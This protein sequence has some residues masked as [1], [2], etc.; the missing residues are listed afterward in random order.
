MVDVTRNDVFPVHVNFNDDDADMRTSKP[1]GFFCKALYSE[2]N[3][4]IGRNE[5]DEGEGEEGL[6]QERA[7]GAIP[8][9]D[10][11]LEFELNGG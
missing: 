1:G 3:S 8:P 10:D 7:G 6:K 2:N 9:P 11:D 5:E 4:E